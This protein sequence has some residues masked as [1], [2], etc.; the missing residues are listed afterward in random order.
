[1]REQWQPQV[2]VFHPDDHQPDS[3]SQPQ[4]CRSAALRLWARGWEREGCRGAAAS[5]DLAPLLRMPKRRRTALAPVPAS[6]RGACRAPLGTLTTEEAAVVVAPSPNRAADGGGEAPAPVG[7]APPRRAKRARA[8]VC[9]MLYVYRTHPPGLSARPI[10]RHA[11]LRLWV[12]PG[13][14]RSPPF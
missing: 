10:A 11:P 9:R 6:P 14:E 12:P 2:S 8:K 5:R 7:D 3:P 4:L 1:M 13:P